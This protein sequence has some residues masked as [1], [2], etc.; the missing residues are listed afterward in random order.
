MITFCKYQGAGNDF[1]MLDNRQGEYD[2]LTPDDV[3]RLCD[4]RFG[5][6]G[7]GLL[8]LTASEDEGVR[9]RM[10][11]YNS[12]GSRAS[13]CGNGARCI[14]AFA[15]E[16][17][18][19]EKGETFSFVADDGRH[20]AVNTDEGVELRMIDVSEIRHVRGGTFLNTGVP[21]FVKMVDDVDQVDIMK[22]APVLRHHRDFGPAGT[23]VNFATATSKASL[24]IRTYE[25]GVE[26]ETLA[27]GTGIVASALTLMEQTGVG[28]VSIEARGGRLTVSAERRA[29]GGFCN[30]VLSGGAE[31]VFEGRTDFRKFKVQ[32]F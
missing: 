26:G 16:K 27:C 24:R 18:V 28:R 9:F 11:Y 13:F 30:I 4:R 6:G 3:A 7:D 29:G 20:Q 10:V 32:S 12:D 21:H 1:V 14:C 5:I 2:T 23:N 31:K 15:R 8:L 17:G 19:V 25:R 22:E